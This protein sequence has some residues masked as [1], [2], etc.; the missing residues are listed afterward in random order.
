M[1]EWKTFFVPWVQETPLFR[2]GLPV[3]QQGESSVKQALYQLFLN[4][5]HIAALELLLVY[6]Q[7]YRRVWESP[8]RLVCDRASMWNWLGECTQAMGER[9][10]G[11]LDNAPHLYIVDAFCAAPATRASSHVA[12]IQLVENMGE[13]DVNEWYCRQ[14]QRVTETDLRSA[15][16]PTVLFP[17]SP[18]AWKPGVRHTNT[19]SGS[20]TERNPCA[21]YGKMV[22]SDSRVAAGSLAKFFSKSPANQVRDWNKRYASLALDYPPRE[23]LNGFGYKRG[24]AWERYQRAVIGAC[25]DASCREP[26]RTMSQRDLESALEKARVEP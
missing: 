26:P 4:G 21:V 5:Q 16:P 6:G 19:E 17:P 18:G 23:V 10:R 12:Q 20:Y 7:Q 24:P 13:L 1:S 3:G 11:I 9:M 15:Y 8:R 25:E 14:Y 22:Q 2:V